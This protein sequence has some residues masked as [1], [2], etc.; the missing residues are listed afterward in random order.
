MSVSGESSSG[1]RANRYGLET[2]AIAIA[3]AFGILQFAR[4]T[5]STLQNL[6]R[7]SSPGVC[8]GPS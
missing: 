7:S 1:G 8:K 6:L 4:N 2:I 5:Y 3:F